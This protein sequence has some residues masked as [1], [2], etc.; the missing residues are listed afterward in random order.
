MNVGS[1]YCPTCKRQVATTE[2]QYRGFSFS[3]FLGIILMSTFTL[4]MAAFHLFLGLFGLI[5]TV[6]L[7]FNPTKTGFRCDFCGQRVE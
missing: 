7:L 5:F 2:M 1:H 3:W 6:A 4:F